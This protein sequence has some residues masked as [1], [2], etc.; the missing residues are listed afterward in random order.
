MYRK[1]VPSKDYR[2][3]LQCYDR[4]FFK[5]ND[6]IGNCMIDLKQ[7]MLDAELTGRPI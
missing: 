3:T 4:D 7:A 6:I 5:S 1:N 2:Y